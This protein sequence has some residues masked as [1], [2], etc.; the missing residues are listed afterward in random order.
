MITA[1]VAGFII[2]IVACVVLV[3]WTFIPLVEDLRLEAEKLN[4]EL[5]RYIE[6]TRNE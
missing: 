1:F 3:S 4:L 6:R 5:S 2:G